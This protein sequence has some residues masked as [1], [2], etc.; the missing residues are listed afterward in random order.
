LRKIAF[1]PR[2]AMFNPS[3][4]AAIAWSRISRDQYSSW[5]REI[6]ASCCDSRPARCCR[7][8]LVQYVTSMPAFS[9]S[10]TNGNEV[11]MPFAPRP[12]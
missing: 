5:S 12:P 7:S 11:S 3:E 10:D 8:M 9:T 6:R 1:A 4:R 2:N